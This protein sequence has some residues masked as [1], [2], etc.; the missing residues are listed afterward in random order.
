M[1]VRYFCD[2]CGVETRSGELRVLVI[3][4]PPRSETFEVCPN[5]A[6]KLEAELDRC[7]KAKLELVGPQQ[8]ES[9]ALA[10][11]QR[12]GSTALELPA[13]RTVARGVSYAVVFIVFFVAVTVLASL[14]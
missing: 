11:V 2:N 4:V 3:S 13:V 7:R 6:S 10:A 9:V 5:C 8:R 14:R 1:A 12:V